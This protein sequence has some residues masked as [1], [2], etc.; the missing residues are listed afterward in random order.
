M[1]CSE[2]M[3]NVLQG[4]SVIIAVRNESENIKQCIQSILDN[5]IKENLYEIIIVDDHSTDDTLAKI[6]NFHNDNIRFIQQK[7]GIN[8]K[9]AALTLGISLAKFP[10]IICTDADSNVGKNWIETHTLAY[11]DYTVKFNTG[12]VLPEMNETILSKFQWLDF[13]A[14]MAITAN[15]IYRQSYFLANGANLSY[16]KHTFDLY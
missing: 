8:G 16:Q 7:E 3:N 15:G 13:A 6:Q 1:P 2:S 11:H 9:K 5:E 4:T 14:T 10:I 12:I